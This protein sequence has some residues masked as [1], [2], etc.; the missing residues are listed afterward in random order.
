MN[1]YIKRKTSKICRKA[2]KSRTDKARIAF[3]TLQN[4]WKSKRLASIAMGNQFFFI[5]LNVEELWK[6]K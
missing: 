5:G 2:D 1:I 3:N 4:I 6:L